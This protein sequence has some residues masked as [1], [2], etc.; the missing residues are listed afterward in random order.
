ML[1]ILQRQA[2]ILGFLQERKGGTPNFCLLVENSD[3]ESSVFL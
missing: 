1:L 3:I 2:S